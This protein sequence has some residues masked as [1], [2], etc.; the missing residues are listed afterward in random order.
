MLQRQLNKSS[1]SVLKYAEWHNDLLPQIYRRR[2]R[3]L[4]EGIVDGSD[5]MEFDLSSIDES[6]FAERDAGR[7]S[8]TVVEEG[9]SSQAINRL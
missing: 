3:L 7:S 9:C 2:F 8:T 6:L 5:E 4:N 1:L